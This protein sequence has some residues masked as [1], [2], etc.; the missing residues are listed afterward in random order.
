MSIPNIIWAQRKDR[1]FLTVQLNDISDEKIELSD[2]KLVFS[3][4]GGPDHKSYAFD[5]EFFEEIESGKSNWKE[6]F[7]GLKLIGIFGLMKMKRKKAPPKGFDWDPESVESSESEDNLDDLD[8][9]DHDIQI[10]QEENLEDIEKLKVELDDD[11][12][13][14]EPIEKVEIDNDDLD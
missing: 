12:E 11:Q 2:S 7:S 14:K 13:Q 1:L 10:P 5:L 9:Q 4:L 6:N 8:E 3:G